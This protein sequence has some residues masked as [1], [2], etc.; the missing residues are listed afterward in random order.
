MNKEFGSNLEAGEDDLALVLA[1][2]HVL[3]NATQTVD[4]VESHRLEFV[5]EHVDEVVL[6]GSGETLLVDGEFAHARDG[7]I[8]HLCKTNKRKS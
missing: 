3:S 2:R 4:G 6:A 1:H 7:G 8:A 5:V